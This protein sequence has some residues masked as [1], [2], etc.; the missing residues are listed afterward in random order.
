MDP[1]EPALKPQWLKSQNGGANGNA[2][3]N[4]NR[5]GI[6]NPNR[7]TSHPCDGSRTRDKDRLGK[8]KAYSSFG[9]RSNRNRNRNRKQ[10]KECDFFDRDSS[11]VFDRFDSLLEI[12][13]DK[14]KLR[15]SRSLIS[16][17]VTEIWPEKKAIDKKSGNSL[18]VDGISSKNGFLSNREFP[19]LKTN[20]HLETG[21]RVSSPIERISLESVAKGGGEG[22][23]SVLVEVPITAGTI[24]S[25]ADR[26]STNGVGKETVNGLNM[27]QAVAQAPAHDRTTVQL[28][29]DPQKV[30]E[31][32]IR[33][34]KQLIPL[35]PSANKNSVARS[36]ERSKI[37]GT[38]PLT[39]SKAGTHPLN[40]SPRASLKPETVTKPMSQL[41]TFQ[42]LNRDKN[43]TVTSAP[44]P[45]VNPI[46]AAPK[47]STT[48]SKRKCTISKQAKARLDFFNFL[49]TKASSNGTVSLAVT[50]SDSSPTAVDNASDKVKSE[51][52]VCGGDK[53]NCEDSKW[54]PP[55]DEEDVSS[56]ELDP[57]EE[58]FLRSLGWDANAEVDALTKEEIDAF[59]IKYKERKQFSMA[60][61]QKVLSMV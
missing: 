27:A 9:T 44:V 1:S 31:L 19:S 4:P 29:V 30:D 3:S 60:S 17:P 22:W 18:T 13:S 34:C 26:S 56:Q 16:A 6:S 58:A 61:Q 14:D 55:A 33:Q 7:L 38:A 35:T 2:T 11:L 10:E 28:T 5:N 37:K 51:N 23:N 47:V 59:N 54:D 21:R 45:P 46:N 41:G 42:I 36:S 20:G 40:S 39:V 50:G 12:R 57:E 32:T 25:G 8:S 15:R 52:W 43:G 49:R 48:V 53:D 24:G